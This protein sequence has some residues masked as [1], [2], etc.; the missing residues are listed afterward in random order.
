[1]QVEIARDDASSRP[2]SH[3]RETVLWLSAFG[4]LS[5]WVFWRCSGFDL[6]ETVTRDG[7]V[8]LNALYTVD[9][10]FHTMRAFQLIESL[11]A[12][13]PLRW[14]T[15]HQGGYPAEFY[16]IGVAW[17]EAIFW[18]LSFGSLTIFSVHKITILLIFLLPGV[19][20]W[21]LAR[22]D[23][24][25]PA[26]GFLALAFQL[27]IAGHWM[28]G[29]YTEVVAWGLVTNVTGATAALIATGAIARY[30]IR[31]EIGMGLLAIS[32]VT[33]SAYANPR[34][35]LAVVVAGVA[36]VLGSQLASTA[37]RQSLKTTLNRVG[38][39]ASISGLMCATEI[40]SLIRYRDLYYFVNYEQYDETQTYWS[41][42][43]N[44]VTTPVIW[45]AIGGAIWALV[46][47]RFP[48]ARVAAISLALYVLVTLIVSGQFGDFDLI[49]QLE[50]PRL[51]PYQ[52]MLM[53][54]LAAFLVVR[55]IDVGARIARVGAA[56]GFA[57]IAI[58][59]LVLI[60][61]TRPIGDVGGQFQGLTEQPTMPISEMDMFRNAVAQADAAAPE[62]TSIL[63]LGTQQ[64]WHQR[65]WASLDTDK[66]LYYEHW[67]WSWNNEHQ[68]P[69][70]LANGDCTFDNDL[71]NYYP[72]PDQTL[73]AEYL[74][75]HGVG[76]VVV[77]DV[78]SYDDTPNARMAAETSSLLTGI[79]TSDEW[80]V[81]AVTAPSALVT[82][83]GLQ[84]TSIDIEN[85]AI[86]ASFADGGGEITVRVNWFPRWQATVNGAPVEVVRGEGGYMEIQVPS[87]AADIQLTYAMTTLDWATRIAAIAGVLGAIGL[88]LAARTDRFRRFTPSPESVHR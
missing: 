33:L 10:P 20:Y 43:V 48:V 3:H 25:G 6:T 27:G 21:V 13:E 19:G 42:T 12:G 23:R 86:S 39:I 87:G 11:R 2:N 54:F 82:N 15:S 36:V 55:L 40:V 65:L 56:R 76:A 57:T 69:P 75:Y 29:G 17:I 32:A 24:K 4:L 49:Q 45:M 14:I 73:T 52:R 22:G 26:T 5:V 35:L 81:Y 78:G 79:S 68:G 8:Y 16:P 7:V 84:P 37:T 34:S 31:G 88:W 38:T 30:A 9:H 51:M 58:A 61:F 1:M 70:A 41:A 60:V 47:R 44:A 74:G 63:V 18:F 83:S 28:A 66:P 64:S 50:A 67:L 77:T 62:G 71:G 72:C 46:S 85:E 80:D 53:L 59:V